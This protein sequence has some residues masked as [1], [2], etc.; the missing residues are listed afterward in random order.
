MDI[1]L[2]EVPTELHR[3]LKAEAA[4]MERTLEEHCI[5]VLRGRIPLFTWTKVKPEFSL[6][7]RKRKR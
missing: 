7:R 4:L 6:A 1:R 5:E 2:R 3:E